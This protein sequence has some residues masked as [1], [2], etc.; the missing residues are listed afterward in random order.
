MK[1]IFKEQITSLE[2]LEDLRSTLGQPSK[3]VQDK[4]IHAFDI[5]SRDFI[6]K[7]PFLLI[8]TAD[9]EG[10]CDVSP[11]GDAPGFVHIIDDK[12]LFIPERPG[13]RRMDSIGNML[14]NPHIGLIFLIPGL[15]E[16]FRVNGKAC[17]SRDQELLERTAV[18][19]KVPLLGIGV[20]IEEGYMHCAKAF[21]RSALW[22]PG[23][24]LPEEERPSAAKIISA[25]VS[26][27][28]RVTEEQVRASLEES[29]TKRL[30]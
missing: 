8:A 27:Q 17:I 14:H 23:S 19:G 10:N 6:A 3:M 20:E 11:R 25:H 5:H 22:Q 30:Y 2:E 16:T 7:S 29:Y 21:K 12:H 15:E 13:N 9:S 1:H 24:W 4:V 18:N 28:R 26:L